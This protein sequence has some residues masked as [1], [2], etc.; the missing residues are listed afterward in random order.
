MVDSTDGT[1]PGTIN[2]AEQIN[3]G[4]KGKHAVSSYDDAGHGTACATVRD[5]VP[6][7]WA[8]PPIS[9]NSSRYRML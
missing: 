5:G 8:G 7:G 3:A 2:T 4:P 6:T 9:N 1:S